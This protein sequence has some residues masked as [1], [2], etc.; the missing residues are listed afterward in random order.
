MDTS[1]PSFCTN[2]TQRSARPGAQEFP[3]F[4]DLDLSLHLKARVPP[5]LDA[6]GPRPQPRP[7]A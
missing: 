7:R 2:W 5:L 4:V 6:A 3:V 1:C